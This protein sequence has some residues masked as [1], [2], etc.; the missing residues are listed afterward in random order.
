MAER[1][2]VSKTIVNTD[3]FLAMP[4]NARALYFQLV[5]NADDDG[6]VGNLRSMVNL[7]GTNSKSVAEL[8]KN[9][10]VY[11]FNSGVAVLLHWRMQNH[12]P[13]DRYT[14]TVYTDEMSKLMLNNKGIYCLL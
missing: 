5:I 9:E 10:Y 8:I 13:K 12:I 14:P 7:C 2:M 11:V 4:S 6:F 1:R 3:K